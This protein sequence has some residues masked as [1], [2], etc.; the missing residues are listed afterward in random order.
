MQLT[1]LLDLHI[2]NITSFD[3]NIIKGNTKDT[4][5]L[6][7]CG[8]DPDLILTDTE[9]SILHWKKQ[10]KPVIAWSHESN[11]TENLMAAPWL[12]LSI[13]AISD[14][15]LEEIYCH[16]HG[17]PYEILKTDR[18]ILKELSVNDYDNL[19]LLDSE[20]DSDSSGRFFKNPSQQTL[21]FLG[22]Y[23][24]N[25]YSFYGIGIYGAWH[26]DSGEFLGVAGFS[27]GEDSAT[28]IG[29]A[30]K[31]EMRRKGYAKEWIMALKEYAREF[32]G[33]DKLVARIKSNNIASMNTAR[34]CGLTIVEEKE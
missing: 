27:T 2:Y 11:R 20:Q 30:V 18:C 6:Q 32:Y 17:I 5:L 19:I 13:D 21:E 10:N 7:V 3:Y 9:E 4:I 25:Q 33:I 1:L 23:C 26:K 34:S 29:Y 24:S 8:Q 31:K 28:E 16:Y 14:S 12:I 22:T 15:Y